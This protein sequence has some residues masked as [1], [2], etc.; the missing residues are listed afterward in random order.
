MLRTSSVD[1]KPSAR[2]DVVDAAL[3]FMAA[4]DPSRIALDLVI[5]M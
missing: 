1:P 3:L 5:H 2:H 4:L